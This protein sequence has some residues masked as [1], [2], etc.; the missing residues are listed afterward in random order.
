MKWKNLQLNKCPKCDK[1]FYKTMVGT[2]K[3]QIL[4]MCGFSI[5]VDKY[6]AI[7]AK[8]IESQLK[9]NNVDEDEYDTDM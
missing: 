8:R 4:C 7:V 1:D 5:S 2:V 6:K 3:G 9:E